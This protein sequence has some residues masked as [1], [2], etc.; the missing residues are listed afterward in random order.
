MRKLGGYFG[1]DAETGLGDGDLIE[2]VLGHQFLTRL[3]IGQLELGEQIG[4]R[5]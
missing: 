1:F 2:Q 5:C 4:Q 3:H